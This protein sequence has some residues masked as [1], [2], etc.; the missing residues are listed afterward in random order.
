MNRAFLSAIVAATL[1]LTANSAL[2][3]LDIGAC[4]FPETPVVPDG[5]T[6][7]GDDMV[8]AS[9]AIKE[10]VTSTEATLKCLDDAK[11][12]AGEEVTE[13]ELATYTDTYNGKVDLLNETANAFNEQVRLYKSREE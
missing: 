9:K 4:S 13:E 8:A 10:Y 11:A 12:A 1:S 5:A 7:T 6:A 2:A 3:A